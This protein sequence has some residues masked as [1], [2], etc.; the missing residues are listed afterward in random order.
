M[1]SEEPT[2]RMQAAHPGNDAGIGGSKANLPKPRK[3]AEAHDGTDHPRDFWAMSS[4]WPRD[5][6]S[7]TLEDFPGSI[8]SYLA[9]TSLLM[10]PCRAYH[11]LGTLCRLR[12]QRG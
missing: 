10:L 12:M 7:M 3:G 2:E 4:F 1:P 6:R 5:D 11:V 9:F 8:E